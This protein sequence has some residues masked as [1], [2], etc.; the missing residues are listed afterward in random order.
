M[1]PCELI[2]PEDCAGVPIAPV[3]AGLVLDLFF[4]FGLCIDPPDI[5]LPVEPAG[6]AML[7]P[8]IEPPD[9]VPELAGV[10]GPDI[11][12]PVCWANA[13]PATAVAASVMIAKA[14]VRVVMD[15]IG[16]SWGGPAGPAV[17]VSVAISGGIGRPQ[18][19]VRPRAPFGYTRGV[20]SS[21]A[22]HK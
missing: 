20:I 12:P 17:A 22:R 9:I 6:D 1:E 11:E 21:A 16:V 8:D 5:V 14:A 18:C 13:V 7:P 2:P 19:L 3:A 4:V 15:F 10:E